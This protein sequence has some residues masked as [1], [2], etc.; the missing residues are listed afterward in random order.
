[1]STLSLKNKPITKTSFTDLDDFVEVTRK[2]HKPSHR[3]GRSD[4]E[5]IDVTAQRKTPPVTNPVDLLTD[6]SR[7][8][9]VEALEKATAPMHPNFRAALVKSN[10]LAPV[11]FYK[12][13]AKLTIDV[14]DP[15]K[16]IEEIGY[17]TLKDFRAHMMF[18]SAL[19][20]DVAFF[21]RGEYLKLSRS[22]PKSD[23]DA[24]V[25]A[26]NRAHPI[27]ADVPVF[28]RGE[29]E[30]QLA[31]FMSEMVDSTPEVEL[32]ANSAA[33]VLEAVSAIQEWILHGLYRLP[34]F[35]NIDTGAA[36]RKYYS[37]DEGMPLKVI[38]LVNDEGNKVRIPVTRFTD[39][40]EEENRKWALK[41][42]AQREAEEITHEMTREQYL[43]T[44]R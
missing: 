28:D 7:G 43:A 39:Y 19:M 17:L 29:A 30:R 23:F 1:M 24:D 41:Q 12:Q 26:Y 35:S 34:V 42:R 22:V 5:H 44:R 8:Y 3:A 25:D 27:A 13:A 6:V 15:V 21:A 31:V 14:E 37:I 33:E 16:R 40:V 2:D 10:N 20:S 9:L 11:L 36:S 18:W 32:Y 38:I 4:C